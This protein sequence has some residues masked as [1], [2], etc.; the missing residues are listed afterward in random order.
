MVS[1]GCHLQCATDCLRH[2]R[3]R[4][5]ALAGVALPRLAA[6]FA[7]ASNAEL[8]VQLIGAVVAPVFALA[9]PGARGARL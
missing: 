6:S 2:L 9:S 5:P 3:F 8:L 4:R 1:T 7:G